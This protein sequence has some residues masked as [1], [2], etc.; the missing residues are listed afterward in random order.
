MRSLL[1]RLSKEIQKII[2][3]ICNKHWF[4]FCPGAQSYFAPDFNTIIF[5]PLVGKFSTYF[6]IDTK[7][8]TDVW[9]VHERELSKLK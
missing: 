1:W 8:F 2:P 6:F 4:I 9:E 5:E 7:R 3:H